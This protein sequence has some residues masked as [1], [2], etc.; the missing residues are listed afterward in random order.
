MVKAS[1][2]LILAADSTAVDAQTKRA[3]ILAYTGGILRIKRQNYVVALD[4]LEFSGQTPLLADHNDG[5]DGLVGHGSAS[6]ESDKLFISGVVVTGDKPADRIVEL[7]KAGQ[8]LQASVGVQPTETQYIRPGEKVFVNGRTITSPDDGLTLV[9]KGILKEV[10][11]C[12]LGAD[13]NTQ[14]FIEAKKDNM[15]TQA[16]IE[17]KT[18]E[19]KA[20]PDESGDLH[21][22]ETE[23]IKAILETCGKEHHEIAIKAIDERWD[24]NKT[25]L[26]VE[27]ARRPKV[28]PYHILQD[29]ARSVTSNEVLEGC[30]FA[31]MGREDIGER[32]LGAETMQRA[33]DTRSRHIMDILAMSLQN[34]GRAI[35]RDENEMI[36]AAVSTTNMQV[37]LSNVANK[38][39]MDRHV[40]NPPTWQSFCKILSVKDFKENTA[41]RITDVGEMQQ[42]APD[43]KL[44]S[45]GLDEATY[46]FSVDTYGKFLK[47]DR[48]DIINDDLSLFAG[49]AEAMAEAA[50]RSVSNLAYSVLLANEHDFFHADN[51]NYLSGSTTA[52][53]LEAV[54]NGITTMR[55]Q[56]DSEGRPID[57]SPAILVVPPALETSGRSILSSDSVE[58]AEGVTTGNGVKGAVSLVVEPRLANATFTGC[59]SKAWYLFAAPHTAPMVMAFLNGKQTP[60]VEF[61]GF[62]SDPHTLAATWRVYHDFGCAFGDPKAAFKAKG[63]E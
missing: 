18:D 59:S 6:V 26:E 61:F 60:T 30:L 33:R 55:S 10:S 34:S 56:T 48:R 8:Q 25:E 38:T 3:K 13:A 4:G 41:I 1:N 28:P 39:M 52:L 63:E 11:I 37:A 23:R 36:R 17:N 44:K 40:Q 15:T 46:T 19:L 2:D 62:E 49:A 35:P 16:T 21:A 24:I 43:G 22:A 20:V 54:S 58:V 31:R 32:T 14:V 12:T 9:T 7:A 51:G 53:S 27:Y 50:R 57:M 5:L 29:S 45:H 42:V 47:I